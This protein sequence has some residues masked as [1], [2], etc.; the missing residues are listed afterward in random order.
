MVRPLLKQSAQMAPQLN[1]TPQ[2]VLCRVLM[3]LPSSQKLRLA[4]PACAMM[5]PRL[6]SQKLALT[7][8]LNALMDCLQWTLA[9]QMP[10]LW[11]V[12]VRALLLSY[13]SNGLALNA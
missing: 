13:S 7:I 2:Q 11:L 4:K 5:E 3:V 6:L 12:M 1:S 10:T 9:Q 8:L